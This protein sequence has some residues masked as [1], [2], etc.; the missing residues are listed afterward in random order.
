MPGRQDCCRPYRLFTGTM[1]LKTANHDW[2]SCF[3]SAT[4]F[5]EDK[6][7]SGR[8]SPSV[9]ARTVSKGG[10]ATASQPVDNRQWGSEYSLYAVLFSTGNYDWRTEFYI[11][12]SMQ[13]ESNLTTVQQDATYSVYYISVGSST[14]FGCWHPSSRARTAVITCVCMCIIR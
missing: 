5:A 3:K 12:G 10:G 14:C 2:Y 4:E 1:L 7:H 11:H 9:N 8:P 13:H 6:P